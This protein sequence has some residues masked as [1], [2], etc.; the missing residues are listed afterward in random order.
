MKERRTGLGWLARD[1]RK[2][3]ITSSA[4]AEEKQ[5]SVVIVPNGWWVVGGGLW[6]NRS[7]WDYLYLFLADDF[8]TIGP[9]RNYWDCWDWSHW[10]GRTN[11]VALKRQ[12]SPEKMR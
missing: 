7:P 4:R 3:R 8:R 10:C 2:G 5:T 11:R 9:C 12:G 1:D 6:E